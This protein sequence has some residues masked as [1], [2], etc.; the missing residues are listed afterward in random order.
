M[1]RPGISGSSSLRRSTRPCRRLGPLTLYNPVTGKNDR[2]WQPPAGGRGYYRTSSLVSIWATAPFLHNN[3]VGAFNGSPQ[4]PDRVN[5]FNE[6]IHKLLW[7][8]ER[9]GVKTIKRVSTRTYFNI[10]LSVLGAVAKQ[11][12]LALAPDAPALLKQVKL[13]FELI[14]H[15]DLKDIPGINELDRLSLKIAVPAGTPINLLANI[16]ISDPEKRLAAV[17]AYVKYAFQTD[18]AAAAHKLP[19]GG[20]ELAKIPEQLAK[21]AMDELLKISEYPDL[22]E[23][24]GHEYGADLGDDDKKA[25]IEYL[26]KL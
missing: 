7:P 22:V 23:D 21:E 4:V 26:K 6:A 13:P 2:V 25:L 10:R 11:K 14:P 15:D 1:R 8:A 9:D 18:L 16:N 12:L 24:H 19:V 3:S 20:A 17:L 5:A